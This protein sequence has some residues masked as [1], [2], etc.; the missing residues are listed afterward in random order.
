MLFVGRV[1]E[2][3]PTEVVAG[4]VILVPRPAS[5]IESGIF[6]GQAALADQAAIWQPIAAYIIPVLFEDYCSRQLYYQDLA[7]N[8]WYR[9]RASC[10]LVTNNS[11]VFVHRGKVTRK[12]LL[13]QVTYDRS[14][15]IPLVTIAPII[16]GLEASY[17]QVVVTPQTQVAITP[18]DI[19]NDTAVVVNLLGNVPPTNP[20]LTYFYILDQVKY[21]VNHTLV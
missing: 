5:N 13:Q 17:P 11:L 16:I 6:I 8:I 1:E 20:V 7:I 14:T 9:L 10:E 19:G 3:L 21:N 15:L 12:L 18:A 4:Q 2:I